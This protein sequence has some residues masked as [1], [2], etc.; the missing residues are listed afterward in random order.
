MPVVTMN[1]K[2]DAKAW[3]KGVTDQPDGYDVKYVG[4]VLET[5]ERNGYDD[6][7]FYA[8]VWDEAEQRV[9]EVEYG[10]T[11][12]WTYPNYAKVDATDEV[13]AKARAYA[14]Q[15]ALEQ[16]KGEAVAQAKTPAVGKS[17]K[18]LKGKQKGK[19]G[20]VFWAKEQGN[21]FAP[22]YSWRAK[23]AL[24]VGVDTG[25][26]R[27]FTAGTNV[28]VT[29]PQDYVKPLSEVEQAARYWSNGLGAGASWGSLTY[30]PRSGWMFV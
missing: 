27:F 13:K 29:N 17:V 5:R 14:Y 22:R 18:V 24:R 28:E 1:E 21:P 30:V 26:E 7:D 10:S 19:E 2:F 4:A 23:P 15:K 8:V 12:F 11:R 6:S 3:E 20:V 25:T 9:K 16:A